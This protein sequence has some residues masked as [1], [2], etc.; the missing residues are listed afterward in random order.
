MKYK[1]LIFTLLLGFSIQA[2]AVVCWNAKG[3]GVV[4]EVFYDLSESFTSSNNTAGSVVQLVR[5]FTN[6]VHAICPRHDGDNRTR[7]SY[8][9]DLPVV[10]TVG[11][12]KYL[13]INDYLLGAMRITD[14]DIGTFYPPANYVLM[15]KDS[16][17]TMERP[18]P[19]FDSNF[20]FRIKV[21]RPFV[22]F[23]PIP[24][25]TLFTVYVTTNSGEPLNTPVYVIAY[26]GSIT[27]PQSC[28]IGTGNFLEINF[29]KI[30]SR[31]FVEGG[32]G[33]KPVGVLEQRKDLRIKCSNIDS[34]ATLT[35]RLEAER[36]S[37]EIMQTDNP[38]IGVKISD[39]NGRVLLPNSIGST[40]PFTYINPDVNVAI[41][42][43]PVSIT[44]K[45]PEAGPFK[46]RGYLRVDFD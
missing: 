7:R 46:A 45:A 30:P 41:R 27:V 1:F 26:S 2:S 21:V 23:V 25:K 4:D 43:W 18:F 40:I 11:S 12:F 38:D 35:L 19:V 39:L 9:T 29:G 13:Q 44:G 3:N 37:N 8:V 15:G 24:R 17:V 28:E 5:S 32:R 10:E 20:T 33:N 6:Q 22:D 36:V 31:A 16:N 42:T 34:Y 14:S